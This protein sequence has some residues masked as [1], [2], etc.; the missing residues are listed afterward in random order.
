MRPLYRKWREP[1]SG[2]YCYAKIYQTGQILLVSFDS[3]KVRTPDDVKIGFNMYATIQDRKSLPAC[4]K[5]QFTKALEL[6][7]KK[8]AYLSRQTA[9]EDLLL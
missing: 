7:N 1:D 6:A 9:F 2:R 3:Q 4:T 5:G 8:I